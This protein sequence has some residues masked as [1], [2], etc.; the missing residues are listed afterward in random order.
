MYFTQWGAYFVGA[1]KLINGATIEQVI[2]TGK[3]GNQILPY[4]SEIS[5]PKMNFIYHKSSASISKRK[6]KS[7][8]IL[9]KSNY[10]L[11]SIKTPIMCL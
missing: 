8:A 2:L 3:A 7:K 4:L 11:I 6:V 5:S 10:Y 9:I 1:M